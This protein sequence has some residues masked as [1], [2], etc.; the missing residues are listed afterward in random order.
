MSS[1]VHAVPQAAEHRTV[2]AVLPSDSFRIFSAT[3]DPGSELPRRHAAWIETSQPTLALVHADPRCPD[4]PKAAIDAAT[5]DKRWT[6][7]PH[8]RFERLLRETAVHVG[9]LTNGKGGFAMG[10]VAGYPKG[11]MPPM[12][13]QTL[14]AKEYVDL[15]AFLLT[16]K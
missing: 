1:V 2:R 5:D 12:F 3:G 6:A 9:L 13:G 10:T 16:L 4:L 14:T 11:V 15:V 7:S 8:Q